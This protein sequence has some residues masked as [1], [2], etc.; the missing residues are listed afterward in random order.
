MMGALVKVS[1]VLWKW[2]KE[3]SLG[4][5]GGASWKRCCLSISRLSK[6]KVGKRCGEGNSKKEELTNKG[7][8]NLYM[9]QMAGSLEFPE[10]SVTLENGGLRGWR[11]VRDQASVMSKSSDFIF[12]QWELLKGFR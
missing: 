3:T 12:S 11:G 5:Q 4:L 1:D 9:W 10:D 2:N 8:R 7:R 6:K